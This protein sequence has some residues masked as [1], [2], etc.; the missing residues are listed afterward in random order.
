MLKQQAPRAVFPL[1]YT[2]V[3]TCTTKIRNMHIGKGKGTYCT[4]LVDNVHLRVF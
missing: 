4:F 3:S 1:R 2:N